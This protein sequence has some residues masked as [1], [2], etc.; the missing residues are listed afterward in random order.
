MLMDGKKKEARDLSLLAI[1][2][3]VF[4]EEEEEAEEP[5]DGGG[6]RGGLDP[7]PFTRE[8]VE[9]ISQFFDPSRVTVLLGQ[10]ARESRLTEPGFLADYDIIHFATHG[11]ID[12][13]RP[14]RSKLALSFPKD[15]TEDGYLQAS[16]IYR[17]DLGA[18]LVVLSACET[19]LGRM[20]RGEGVLGLPRAF[21]Y[22]GA[23]SVVVSLWSVSD[24]STSQ[25]MAAF[26][27]R[28]TSRRESPAR[29]LAGAKADLRKGGEFTHPFYWSPF[30]LMG[31]F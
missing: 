6:P 31:T 20:V 24:R 2:D 29:A 11:L 18:D 28:M 5:S 16:E 22:A 4:G 10:D 13:R 23:S 7:L 17:L 19:G 21:F 9:T 30:V 3:P 14:E 26:Y 8:E 15:P 12:E 1:G 25:L 27:Q